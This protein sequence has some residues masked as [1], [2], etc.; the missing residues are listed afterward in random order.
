M[1]TNMILFRVIHKNRYKYRELGNA[2]FEINHHCTVRP[3]AKNLLLLNSCEVMYLGLF[4][5]LKFLYIILCTCMIF[6]V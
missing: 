3:Y 1:I 6:A 5:G 2:F 4:K